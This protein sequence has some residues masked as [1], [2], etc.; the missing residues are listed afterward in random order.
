MVVEDV[1]TLLEGGCPARL[2]NP[3][4]LQT[5]RASKVS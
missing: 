2:V 5:E 1:R 3:E 4:V